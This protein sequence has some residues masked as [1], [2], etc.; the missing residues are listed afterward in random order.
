MLACIP[1]NQDWVDNGSIASV[2]FRQ[3]IFGSN[4]I[5]LSDRPQEPQFS[6]IVFTDANLNKDYCHVLFTSEVVSPSVIEETTI[7][8]I[9]SP[10]MTIKVPGT[11]YEE[12]TEAVEEPREE[13]EPQKHVT[14]AFCIRS[15]SEHIQGLRETLEAMNNNITHILEK[16]KSQGKL[17]SRVLACSETLRS[18]LWLLN[19]AFIP[20]PEVALVFKIGQEEVE[21][22]PDPLFGLNHSEACFKVLFD[23][24]DVGQIITLYKS[25]MLEQ[26]VTVLARQ[27]QML[28]CICEA[29]RMLMFP[30]EW[31]R[32][33]TPL[34]SEHFLR[35]AESFLGTYF[36]GLNAY[37]AVEDYSTAFEG[38]TMLDIA[39]SRLY[40][41]QPV[42]LCHAVE[43]KLRSDLQALKMPQYTNF[44]VVTLKGYPQDTPD[45]DASVLPDSRPDAYIRKV[46]EAF[47]EVWQGAFKNYE[48]YIFKNSLDENEFNK[49]KFLEA[50]QGCGDQSCTCKDFWSKVINTT[51]FDEFVRQSRWLNDSNAT[52]LKNLEL[53]P[54]VPE[55]EEYE[56]VMQPKLSLSQIFDQLEDLLSVLD[57]KDERVHAIRGAAFHTII[58]IKKQL[59]IYATTIGTEA[60]AE[61]FESRRSRTSIPRTIDGSLS[62]SKPLVSDIGN[63][64]KQQSSLRS[65]NQGEPFTEHNIWYGKIG[66]LNLL[67]GLEILDPDDIK[68][69]SSWR[70]AVEQLTSPDM[71]WQ[72]HLIKA[73]ILE[74]NQGA[75]GDIVEE[76]VSAFEKQPYCLPKYSFAL[77]LTD[78]IVIKPERVR[79]MVGAKGDIRRIAK[80]VWDD[81]ESELFDITV[82]KVQENSIGGP[83]DSLKS[84]SLHVR[85][86]RTMHRLSADSPS[87]S[88]SKSPGGG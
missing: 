86:S 85:T 74:L 77:S 71:V 22:P 38:A 7:K 78:L 48:T 59:H 54:G 21:L 28:F 26:S 12:M 29:L 73:Q 39:T 6:T 50:F 13:N 42:Q 56:Y 14:I 40:V 45:P 11:S 55:P 37:L 31:Q 81:K 65:L 68:N 20:P 83:H 5:M 25:L 60:D 35:D 72:E 63:S 3:A 36:I 47:L 18:M 70:E 30:L 87:K 58:S 80:A 17:I 8:A 16:N 61:L 27:K 1:Y 52:R 82:A 53:P 19:E 24:L 66:L 32:T 34:L 33:Y 9:S 43:A 4:K 41:P 44:D 15:K 67:R 69:I 2:G 79:E 49:E 57:P 84:R 10:I 62:A 23:V 46:R 88:P 51:T 75:P 76:Y 64:F